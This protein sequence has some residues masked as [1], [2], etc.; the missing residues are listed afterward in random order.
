MQYH[1][2]VSTNLPHSVPL[3]KELRRAGQS[4]STLLQFHHSSSFRRQRSQTLFRS[5][6][7][8][9]SKDIMMAPAFT[10]HLIP[11]KGK[12]YFGGKKKLSIPYHLF[13]PASD[14]SYSSGFSVT[15]VNAMWLI[16]VTGTADSSFQ[17][18]G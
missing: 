2:C 11:A 3:I 14:S 18:H 4:H 12:N 5:E 17:V 16:T 8:R 13:S 1:C 7:A 15:A 9:N 6:V 10:P